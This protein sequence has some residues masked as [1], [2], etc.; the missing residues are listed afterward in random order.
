M[1]RSARW[2]PRRCVARERYR[3][4]GSKQRGNCRL[5]G[6]PGALRHHKA[7]A[8]GIVPVLKPA[9]NTTLRLIPPVFSVSLSLSLSRRVFTLFA[10]AVF[11]SLCSFCPASPLPA[12][13]VSSDHF[14]RPH[15]PSI[16]LLSLSLSLFLFLSTRSLA[17]TRDQSPHLII[18][19]YG[20]NLPDALYAPRHRPLCTVSRRCVLYQ[21]HDLSSAAIPRILHVLHSI[22]S[23]A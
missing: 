17:T 19:I 15:A 5:L 6:P 4:D 9:S 3:C 16:D 1:H 11:C 13:Y 20:K 18:G 23:R 8:T 22:R 12:D 10:L 7:Y 14:S 21:I 2:T